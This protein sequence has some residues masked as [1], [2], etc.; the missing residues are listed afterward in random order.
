MDSKRLFIVGILFLAAL[1][2][3]Q[4]DPVSNPVVSIEI[5]PKSGRTTHTFEFDISKSSSSSYKSLK[6]FSRWD[7]DGDGSWDTPYS[8]YLHYQHRYYQPG[9][10][11]TRVEMTNVDGL[12]TIDTILI[13]VEQGYSSPHG[14]LDITPVS[15]N[16][17][18]EFLLDA[19]RSYD[20][21]DSAWTLQY[22]WDFESDDEWDTKWLDTPRITHVYPEP[23]FYKA[24]VAVR[25]PGLRFSGLEKEIIVSLYDHNMVADFTWFPD[26]VVDLTDIRFDASASHDPAHP[27]NPLQYRW[28]FESDY[29]WDT[30]WLDEPVTFHAFRYLRDYRVHLEIRNSYGLINDTVKKIR[31]FHKNRLPRAHFVSSAL[32]G[33]VGTQFRFETYGIRDTESSP[34]SM[35]TQWDF[36]GDGIWDTEP[37]QGVM[38][39]FHTFDQPGTYE[40]TLLVQDPGG[41]QDTYSRPI[42]IGTGS[43][44]TSIL[45]DTRGSYREYYG[46]AKIGDQWWM[47]R[48]L[49][50]KDTFKFCQYFYDRN[51]WNY[52][53]YGHLYLHEYLRNICPPGWHLPSKDE[54]QELFDQF[55]EETRFDDLMPGGSSGF[56]TV[57]GGM[58]DRSG[59]GYTGKDQYG[60]YWSST[61]PLDP[62][63][64]SVW[65]ITFDLMNKRILKGYKSQEMSAYSVRCV[66]D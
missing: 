59:A 39:V 26:S 36:D 28:D 17:L 61:T 44:E 33:H 18:T 13:A 22:R 37:A 27:D 16:I 19:S 25:D 46:T 32:G 4:K 40:V 65:I 23:G 51:W 12:S 54:W 9:T 56:N 2:T 14:F 1:T 64:T 57:F 52:Y 48:N 11:Q 29:M 55:D 45:F 34:T 3:C 7:W 42:Y 38:E 35:I 6:L 47:A 20:D 63:S 8:H 66:K 60:Y 49:C 21:E 24:R 53:D 50:V 43:G 30:E 41:L 15:G 5:H 58:L 10:Y 31:V 62:H